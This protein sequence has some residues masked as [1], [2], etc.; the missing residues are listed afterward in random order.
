MQM[1]MNPR[2]E[3]IRGVDLLDSCK[4]QQGLININALAL[5]HLNIPL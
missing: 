3:D 4:A 2:Y 1:A 5:P